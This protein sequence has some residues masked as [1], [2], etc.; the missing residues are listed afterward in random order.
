M[1]PVTGHP[2]RTPTDTGRQKRTTSGVEVGMPKAKIGMDR[3]E[4]P[5]T[6]DTP[7][8][9]FSTMDGEM[10]KLR[11]DTQDG[12][13]QVSPDTQS[14][15]KAADHEPGADDL[16]VQKV[17]DLT[18]RAVIAGNRRT[19][20]ICDRPPTRT[21]SARGQHISRSGIEEEVSQVSSGSCLAKTEGGSSVEKQTRQL[22]LGTAKNRTARLRF[23]IKDGQFYQ[24]T[25][26]QPS[27]GTS[28]AE[29]NTGLK[30]PMTSRGKTPPTLD[31]PGPDSED[32]TTTVNKSKRTKTSRTRNIRGQQ[33]KGTQ[34]RKGPR[35]SSSIEWARP[36]LYTP[37][38][39]AQ[40]EAEAKRQG[41]GL[42]GPGQEVNPGHTLTTGTRAHNEPG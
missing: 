30:A 5:N 29:S 20:L 17:E 18:Q 8:L 32:L 34:A 6:E 16:V 35:P 14:Q 28:P 7:L 13:P 15:E 3:S 33:N 21:G 11:D 39:E 4:K 25:E 26:G 24:H 9:I 19:L 27:P 1:I 36:H 23:R 42:G 40:T 38:T 41:K 12:V 22:S 37:T 31:P 10:S 2:P